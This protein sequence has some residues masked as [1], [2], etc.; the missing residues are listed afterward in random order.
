MRRVRRSA[1]AESSAASTVGGDHLSRQHSAQV[2]MIE[3]ITLFWLFFMASTFVIQLQV[4]DPVSVASDSALHLAGEDAWIIA[5]AT[6]AIGSEDSRLHE[7]LAAGDPTAACSL[8]LTGLSETVNGNCW[9]AVDAGP[10]DRYG[11]GAVPKGRSMTV[12]H[13]LHA[14]GAVWTVGIQ[15]WH[16]GGGAG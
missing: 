9:L 4:P 12:H 14:D 2:H 10:L 13:M 3:M 15:V 16:V 7:L 11:S 5:T 1:P 8:L 6:E